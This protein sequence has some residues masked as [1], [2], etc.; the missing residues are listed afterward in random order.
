LR[1][2][3][4]APATGLRLGVVM[5]E[6][7]QESVDSQLLARPGLPL[8]QVEGGCVCCAPEDELDRACTGL[9]RSGRCDYLVVETSGLADPDH[10]IDVLTDPDLLACVRLQAIVVVLDAAWYAQPAEPD[11]ER[12]LAR[13]QIQ[14]ADVVALSKCDL[15]APGGAEG[16]EEAV[17]A[18]NPRARLVRMPFGLPDPGELLRGDPAEVV[19]DPA[20]SAARGPHL[21]TG[22]RS[23]TWR[24]PV[25]VER[26][27]FEK[28]LAGL[29]PRE[30]VRAK[31]FVRFR[32][33]PE[34]VF[35]FQSVFGHHFI[36]E[37]PARPHPE[38]VAVLIGPELDPAAHQA[39]LRELCFGTARALP[40]P[41]NS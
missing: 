30:V 28:F 1:W 41:L 25:P 6:F 33:D 18:L 16:V 38:P 19:I 11:A 2:L 8:A 14:F 32:H 35:V 29:P 24:F 9:A 22:Y 10:V 27:A 37:F 5:N 23:V 26:A 34:R 31:G 39:R 40:R 21:H 7:G 36:E 12:I 20:E 17:R 3:R 15:L 13:R 4:E